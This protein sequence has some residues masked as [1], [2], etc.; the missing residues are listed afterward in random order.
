MRNMWKCAALLLAL[1]LGMGAPV[2][3]E[4][5]SSFWKSLLE[6]AAESVGIAAE[7]ADSEAESV[8]ESLPAEPEPV[9]PLAIKAQDIGDFDGVWNAFQLTA[10]GT[11]IVLDE[12]SPDL[13]GIASVFGM[14]DTKIRIFSG[15]VDLFGN[16]D[17]VQ[18]DFADGKL[19]LSAGGGLQ[20][21]SYLGR[22]ITLM[23]DGT[24]TYSSFGMVFACEKM[25]EEETPDSKV[26]P[27]T[28]DEP[29]VKTDVTYECIG[30]RVDDYL[31]DPESTGGSCFLKLA[32]D[33]SAEL[34]VGGEPLSELTWSKDGDGVIVHYYGGQE[35]RVVPN[36]NG[37]E[38]DYLGKM[39]MLFAEASA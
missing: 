34:V 27:V 26:E 30:I 28:E 4:E 13:G 16:S 36:E 22:E 33:G 37:L 17:P 8:A 2:C 23:D 3:A 24:M 32:G 12:N 10:S 11:T 9:G 15:I 31:T 38:M 6:K 18:Y 14:K 20:D 19:Q 35:L 1:S 21:L 5:K 39:T 7:N 29:L 25:Q